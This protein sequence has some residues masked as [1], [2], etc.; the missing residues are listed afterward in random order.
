MMMC[1]YGK[2]MP[3]SNRKEMRLHPRDWSDRSCG[4]FVDAHK[5]TTH[6]LGSVIGKP[7][8]QN[9]PVA[10]DSQAEDTARFSLALPILNSSNHSVTVKLFALEAM[11]RA[12]KSSASSVVLSQF[13]SIVETS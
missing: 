9:D 8:A 7:L 1:C 10:P 2:V 5:H 4:L 6:T 11:P 12:R 13:W 3:P